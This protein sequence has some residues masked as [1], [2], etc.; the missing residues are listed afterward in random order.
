MPNL[1]EG[2]NPDLWVILPEIIVTV[3]A[4]AVIFADLFMRGPRKATVLPAVITV[5]FLIAL[6]VC[7]WQFNDPNAVAHDP[8]GAFGGMVVVDNLGLFFK[9]ISMG[10][11]ILA[12]LFFT[13]FIQERGIQIGD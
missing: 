7:I 9:I 13:I 12:V 3:F 5:G 10:T 1:Y 2:L 4:V 6:G 8:A 11:A